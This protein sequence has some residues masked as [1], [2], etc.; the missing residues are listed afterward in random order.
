LNK[1][2][3][4]L[5]CQIR[6]YF[7]TTNHSPVVLNTTLRNRINYLHKNMKFNADR[8]NG[9]HVLRYSEKQYIIIV[10]GGGGGNILLSLNIE[11]VK[12]R[13]KISR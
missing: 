2:Y 5:S 4:Y 11:M 13:V 9:D 12:L 3:Y 7:G 1:I 10:R 6:K 8:Q